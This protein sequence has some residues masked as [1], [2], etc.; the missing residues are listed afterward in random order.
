MVRMQC[1]IVGIKLFE[2]VAVVTVA[3]E[4]QDN[5]CTRTRRDMYSLHTPG[6]TQGRLQLQAS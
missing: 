5:Q 1:A 2:H 6:D 4:K 3:H